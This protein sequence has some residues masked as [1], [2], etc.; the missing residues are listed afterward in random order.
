MITKDTVD[1]LLISARTYQTRGEH[2]K[3]LDNLCDAIFVLNGHEVIVKDPHHCGVVMD[4]IVAA[5]RFA[6]NAEVNSSLRALCDAIV[7]L[8]SLSREKQP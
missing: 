5:R 8:Y 1:A 4:N 2:S 7:E 6:D 3:A